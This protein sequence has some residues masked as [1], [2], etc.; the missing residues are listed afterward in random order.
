MNERN[1]TPLLAAI[2]AVVMIAMLFVGMQTPMEQANAAPAAAITPVAIEDPVGGSDTKLIKFYDGEVLTADDQNCIDLQEFRVL[3]LEFVVDQ[4]IASE[5]NNTTTVV[6]EHTNFSGATLA[7][8]TTG[9]TVVSAN[10]L[11][12]DDLNRFDL[13]GQYTCVD[14]DVTNTNPV[15]WTVYGVA[16]K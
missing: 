10:A 3:D 7:V 4:T 5:V 16:R 1:R 15:T 6:L 9:Q 14:I 11:D 2:F 8:N 12:A 13:F